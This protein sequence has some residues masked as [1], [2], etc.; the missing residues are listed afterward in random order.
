MSGPYLICPTFIELIDH[1]HE[2]VISCSDRDGMGRTENIP[3]AELVHI[4]GM[5]HFPS[6]VV[7]CAGNEIL[8]RDAAPR[9]EMPSVLLLYPCEVHARALLYGLVGIVTRLDEHVEQLRVVAA[10]MLHDRQAIILV[11]IADPCT[12]GR[13]RE[14]TEHVR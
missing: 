8:D 12:N 2:V 7:G 3:A 5:P 1:G 6:D 10:R 13:E 14:F 11:N 4:H 9:C